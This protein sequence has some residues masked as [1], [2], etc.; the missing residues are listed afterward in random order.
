V[1]SMSVMYL[2]VVVMQFSAFLFCFRR[3]RFPSYLS[4]FVLVGMNVVFSGV[5]VSVSI[6]LDPIADMG[7]YLTSIFSP[8]C[9][10]C[11]VLLRPVFL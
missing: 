3:C 2:D 1:V 5:S 4:C 7:D 6:V 8:Y 10:V 11:L 9:V